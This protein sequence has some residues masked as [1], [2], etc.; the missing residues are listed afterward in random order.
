MKT[1]RFLVIVALAFATIFTS[2]EVQ[3]EEED[4]GKGSSSSEFVNKLQFGSGINAQTKA[5]TGVATTFTSTTDS[6]YF[7]LDTKDDQAGRKIRL[8]FKKG[9]DLTD[10]KE[11]PSVQS[12]GHLFNSKFARPQAGAYSI[13]AFMVTTANVETS[14]LT[15]TLTIE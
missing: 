8:K 7:R 1:K 2:C 13:E 14:V 5:L 4:G 3:K 11:F 9:S 12:F 15:S 10:T 6:I